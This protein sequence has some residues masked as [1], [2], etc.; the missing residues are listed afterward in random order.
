MNV[1]TFDQFYSPLGPKYMLYLPKELV[2]KFLIGPLTHTLFEHAAL[3]MT[4]R[5]ICHVLYK[6]YAE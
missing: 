2:P 1:K 3:C 5:D 6:A 4:V